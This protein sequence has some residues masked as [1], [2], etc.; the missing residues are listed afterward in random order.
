MRGP[1]EPEPKSEEFARFE[2]TLR[3]LVAVPKTE[4]DKQRQK[5]EREKDD[6]VKG[7]RKR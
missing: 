5:Y 7:S 2:K 1:K 3:G 6:K 4:V